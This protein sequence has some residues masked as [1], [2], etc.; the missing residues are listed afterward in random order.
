MKSEHI[1]F[2]EWTEED[3]PLAVQLWGDEDV[4]KYICYSGKFSENDIL[5]RLDTEINNQRQYNVQY[6]PIFEAV[7][8]EFIG[9]CGLRPFDTEESSYEVGFHLCKKFWGRGYAA[10]AAA[11]VIRYGFDTLKVY[12]LYAGHHPQNMK[13]KKLLTRLGFSYIRDSFYKPTGLYHPLYE[14]CCIKELNAPE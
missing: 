8:G 14:M 6:W 10:E 7:S 3:L 2:S 4:T 5:D 9:C 11:Q 1:G 13:S 12:K